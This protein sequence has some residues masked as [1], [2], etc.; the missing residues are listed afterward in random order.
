MFGWVIVLNQL[1]FHIYYL[2][3]EYRI[4]ELYVLMHTYFMCVCLM[5]NKRILQ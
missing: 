5:S 1:H 4:L 3:V 2:F